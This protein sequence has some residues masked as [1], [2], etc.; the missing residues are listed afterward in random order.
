MEKIT[1]P[2]DWEVKIVLMVI[3]KAAIAE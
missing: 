2:I 3:K 1:G